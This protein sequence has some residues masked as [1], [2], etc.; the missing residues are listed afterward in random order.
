MAKYMVEVSGRV[1]V[2]GIADLSKLKDAAG[3]WMEM[4]NFNE[5]I[6]LYSRV[7]HNDPTDWE[8]YIGR[9][10]CNIKAN[11][12]LDNTSYYSAQDIEK[13][14]AMAKQY[15]SP[16]ELEELNKEKG[17]LDLKIAKKQQEANEIVRKLQEEKEERQREFEWLEKRQ[18]FWDKLPVKLSISGIPLFILACLLFF[19]TMNL[20][21]S[22]IFAV[23]AVL[24]ILAAIAIRSPE[25]L[26]TIGQVLLI[27]IAL[28]VFL[29]GNLNILF[30]AAVPAL[31]ILIAFILEKIRD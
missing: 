1:K 22:A 28:I 15:A 11:I 7:I 9:C 21:I 20:I 16:K 13:D 19:S 8:A 17:L 10:L 12:R 26:K 5:A 4:G 18:A 30:F 3:K 23:S 24:L 6:S 29:T 2:D 27:P 31:L 14:Y 25:T